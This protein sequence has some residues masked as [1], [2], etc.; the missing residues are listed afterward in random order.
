M[1]SWMDVRARA[2][3]VIAI[4]LNLA[5]LV[6]DVVIAHGRSEMDVEGMGG[7]L[8][9]GLTVIWLVI[10][11]GLVPLAAAGVSLPLAVADILGAIWA[12]SSPAVEHY[13]DAESW[14]VLVA[15][16]GLAGAC[17]LVLQVLRLSAL[18][19]RPELK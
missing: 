7:L 15:F 13:G 6:T 10:L 5:A 9:I 16:F 1:T 8:F 14:S 11:G 2:L 19:S 4:C 18:R 17:A 3:F 12:S